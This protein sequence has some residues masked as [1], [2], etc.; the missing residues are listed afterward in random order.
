MDFMT[1]S[2]AFLVRGVD[3]KIIIILDWFL[4]YSVELANALAHDHDVMLVTRDHNFEISSADVPT[5]LDSFLDNALDHKVQ[6]LKL[7]Y[8]RGA[9]A[10][11]TEVPRVLAL[12]KSFS[13]DIV[14]V[15]ETT[16]WRILFLLKM[17]SKKKRVLTI[18]DVVSH[19][20]EENGFLGNISKLLRQSVGKII[21]HGEFLRQQLQQNDSDLAATIHVVPHGV[22]S[23]YKKWDVENVAEEDMTILFFG[24][25]SKYKG[26]NILL[27]AHRQVL[28]IL[29]QAKLVI[30]GKGESLP[31]DVIEEMQRQKMEIHHKF[32]ANSEVFRF[33]RRAAVVVLPYTEA[34]QSGVVPIAYSFG[35]PVVVTSVGSIPEVVKNGESGF[36]V[37][38][39]DPGALAEALVKIFG[40]NELRR[41][42]GNKA[43]VMAETELS[44][45]AISKRTVEIYALEM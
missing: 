6:R 42:M 7:R 40:D 17:F 36:V 16:D 8:R 3:M 5:T 37:P 15:Q 2:T 38:P 30:A 21:L 1:V 34:S 43:L 44:W 32:I 45:G 25:L 26:L 9:I 41:T 23:I 31:I 24:R 19:P 4:Y 14:H 33:F 35:K 22:L 11:L 29:P 13:P 18:H 10:N 12:L 28:Q 39:N 27:E 20:G